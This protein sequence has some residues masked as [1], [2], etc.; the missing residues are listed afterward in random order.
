MI[1][2]FTNTSTADIILD[3]EYAITDL[4]LR[5]LFSKCKSYYELGLS[6]KRELGVDQV[7]G[8]SSKPNDIMTGGRSL[9]SFISIYVAIS[10]A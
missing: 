6:K 10:L 1:T 5:S 4:L 9:S 2:N 3:V 8:I 7:I